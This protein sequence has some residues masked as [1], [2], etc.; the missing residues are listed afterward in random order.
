MPAAWHPK[1]WWDWCVSVDEMK[2]KKKI[3]PMFI[4]VLLKCES[5]VYNMGVL[6]HF[7]LT[8]YKDFEL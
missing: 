6:K 3:D 8:I 2:K 1:R 7:E 4:E 5:V